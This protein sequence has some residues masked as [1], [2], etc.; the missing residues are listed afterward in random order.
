MDVSA[1]ERER[2]GE[3]ERV[4]P[5]L[6][7]ED[8]WTGDSWPNLTS[9]RTPVDAAKEKY[10]KK[11]VDAPRRSARPLQRGKTDAAKR[12]LANASIFFQ[13]GDGAHK[14]SLIASAI[15]YLS[16]KV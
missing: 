7:R 16:E 8:G 11:K 9:P 10:F 2:H 15:T 1:R 12:K 3:R 4:G 13:G 6:R 14:S 5:S